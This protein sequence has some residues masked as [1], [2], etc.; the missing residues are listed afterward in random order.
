MDIDPA[1]PGNAAYAQPSVVQDATVQD[2]R[3]HNELLMP[4]I[5][6]LLGEDYSQPVSYTHL[7]L[8]TKRI[9]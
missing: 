3:A 5:D 1:Q 9:V 8:P 4:T 7:T 2:T 6:D